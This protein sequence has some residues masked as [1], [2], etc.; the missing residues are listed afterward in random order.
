MKRVS[1]FFTAIA[2]LFLISCTKDHIRG[3]GPK[4]TV[5]RNVANFTSVSGSGNSNVFITQGAEFKVEIKGYSNLLSYFETKVINNE[6]QLGYRD[7]I[8]VKNDNVEV[9]ITMPF[10]T[11][12]KLSGSGEIKTSGNF[13][14]NTRF[15][16][17]IAGSGNITI[18]QGSAKQFFASIAGSGNINA[19]NMVAEKAEINSTGSGNTEIT[20]TQE[21]KVR[22]SGS[23]NV[24]YKG[25]PQITTEIAG[26]GNVLPK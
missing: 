20:A 3:T 7:N 21:L 17:F 23:G 8:S 11:G 12:V 22:I 19:I 24:Y 16:A 26:S 2:V 6:L 1:H 13:S 5:T 4:D 14:G 18:A 10:L 25:S 15:E 9:F